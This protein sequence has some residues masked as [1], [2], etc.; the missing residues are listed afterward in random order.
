MN[1]RG[2]SHAGPYGLACSNCFKAKSKC[3]AFSG[4]TETSAC[5][6]CHRLGKQCQ[7]SDSIRP[8]GVEKK[9]NTS[10][11]RIEELE[12]KVDSL[13]MELRSRGGRHLAGPICESMSEELV[14]PSIEVD[15]DAGDQNDLEDLETDKTAALNSHNDD[16]LAKFRSLMLPNFPFIYLPVTITAQALETEWP[17]LF[18]AIVFVA[19]ASSEKNS[20]S[21]EL[22]R[23]ICE[24]LLEFDHKPTNL[25]RTGLLLAILT[26]LA[27]GGDH[28]L[29]G[30][31]MPR[32]M[33]QAVSLATEMMESGYT[34]SEHL[35]EPAAH[36]FGHDRQ[37]D[38]CATTRRDF[39]L[40]RRRAILGC[41]VI[42][43]AVS[44][45]FGRVNT[46]HWTMQMEEGLAAIR[47]NKDCP[48]DR[49][50]SLLVRSQLLAEKASQVSVRQ[51]L[52]YRGSISEAAIS[53]A[54]LSLTSLRNELQGL[55]TALRPVVTNRQLAMAHVYST[56]SRISQITHAISS[57]VPVM[58]SQFERMAASIAAGQ[59]I[60]DGTSKTTTARSDQIISLWQCLQSST[61]CILAL[62][63]WE[64]GRFCHMS[65]LQWSQLAH[66]VACL[67]YLT[68]TIE[69]QGWDREA[70]RIR[71]DMP[72]LL[73][74]IVEKLQTTTETSGQ[75][76]TDNTFSL[77]AQKMTELR[78]SITDDQAQKHTSQREADAAW[79]RLKVNG[80]GRGVSPCNLARLEDTFKRTRG[81]FDY[82]FE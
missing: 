22:M 25:N 57:T 73:D 76:G 45:Y 61:D 64:S 9:I 33:T 27:W 29:Y 56:E 67:Y 4:T 53:P 23:L 39:F 60:V 66:G 72:A 5:R 50:F 81:P 70:V 2:P 42:N 1:R 47:A 49:D 55:R 71:V 14:L 32:L 41:F 78:N 6:R 46:F 24:S 48:S 19:S 44:A 8:R 65:F 63:D 59:S 38:A 31:S 82:V 54:T 18:K 68:H 12:G 3:V 79:E 52:E 36:F 77:S 10:R 69:D 75:E 51:K 30:G 13:L 34:D 20:Q 80:G 28:I 62:L 58:I 37:R 26:Y 17:I 35:M 7:P 15:I 11:T 21:Q 43:S 40:D 16:L 74:R